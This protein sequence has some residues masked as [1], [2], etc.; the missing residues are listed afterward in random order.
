MN[1]QDIYSASEH[2]E[3]L[4]NKVLKYQVHLKAVNIC[5]LTRLGFEIILRSEQKKLRNMK[6]FYLWEKLQSTGKYINKF[7]PIINN[8]S[9]KFSTSSVI[10][11]I[12]CIFRNIFRF[13]FLIYRRS[14]LEI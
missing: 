2:F 14:K 8:I 6:H 9:N 3:A 13:P 11:A 7:R 4:Y 12:R 5:A 1:L 10:L